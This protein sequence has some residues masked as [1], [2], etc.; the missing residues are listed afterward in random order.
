[1]TLLRPTEEG[2][3]PEL[4]RLFALRFGHA[5]AAEEWEWKYR[6]LPGEARSAVALDGQGRLVAHAGALKLPA[7]W[8]GGEGGIWQL[9]DF[10]G[11]PG[12]GLA[13]PL[14]ELGRWLLGDLPGPGDAPWIFGFPSA[15]HFRLGERAFGYLPL[16]AVRERAGDLA[17]VPVEREAG[18]RLPI[19]ASDHCGPWAEVVWEA[20]GVCGVRRT[21]AFLNW[22]Y[23]A[24]P[25]RY[26]RFYR[27]GPEG[28]EGL[29]VF[30]FVGREARAAELWLPPGRGLE[31]ALPALA[32]DLLESGLTTWRFWPPPAGGE[33]AL[34]GLGLAPAAEVFVGCRGRAGAADPRPAAAGFH[35]AMGD[36]DLT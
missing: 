36:W 4:S 31:R 27:L 13:P 2:D 5:L 6:R 34:A 18:R 22:R 17:H 30:A 24:R 32:A 1:V 8:R 19:E 15:R 16:P 10:V 33:P 23:H 12:R 29:A 7:R 9:A 11:T 21:P 3:L 26:Y 14:V 28:R 20:C 35:L 25:G